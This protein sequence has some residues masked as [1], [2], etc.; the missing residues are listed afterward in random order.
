MDKMKQQGKCN[1][2]NRER[3]F[4][5][6]RPTSGEDVFVHISECDGR[7]ELNVGD[8][9]EFELASHRG[10]PCARSVSVLVGTAASDERE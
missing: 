10:K 1:F 9:V 2:F 3:G 8:L 5:F 4:G 6:I 7:R